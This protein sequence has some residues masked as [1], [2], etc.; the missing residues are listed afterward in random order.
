MCPS[1]PAPPPAPPPPLPYAPPTPPPAPAPAPPPVSRAPQRARKAPRTNTT[2]EI[3][4][5]TGDL[6][7][8]KRK[9]GKRALRIEDTS[10]VNYPGF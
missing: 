10:G 8:R 7:I 1:S 5:R 3:A 6:S 2:A 9:T 4:G